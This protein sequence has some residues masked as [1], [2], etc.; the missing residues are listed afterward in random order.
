MKIEKI[1]K[2]ADGY[3]VF[4][5]DSDMIAFVHKKEEI[6]G[7]KKAGLIKEPKPIKK[8]KEK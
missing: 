6:D 2:V 4:F 8:K 5:V 7:L 3:H 1:E